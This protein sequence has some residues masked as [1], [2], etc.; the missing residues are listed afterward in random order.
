MCAACWTGCRRRWAA[1]TTVER[2]VC[3]NIGIYIYDDAEVL[4]FSGPFEVFSTA[5]RLQPDTG[6]SVFLVGQ[7]GAP[8]KARYGFTVTPTC[9]FAEHPHIDVL[10]VAGGVHTGALAS[11]PV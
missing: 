5:A 7:T 2:S 8:V 9:G 11:S 10:L 6:I 4:D 1:S 3:I